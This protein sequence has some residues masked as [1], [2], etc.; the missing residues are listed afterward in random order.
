MSVS[1]GELVSPIPGRAE[2][3]DMLCAGFEAAL[4]I[5]LAEAAP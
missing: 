2:L 4:G 5:T 3:I 1:L